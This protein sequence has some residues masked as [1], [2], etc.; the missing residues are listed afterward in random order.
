MYSFGKTFLFL[1][2]TLHEE[3][4]KNIQEIL[5]MCVNENPALR[6][7]D[8]KQVKKQLVNLQTKKDFYRVIKRGCLI[9]LGLSIICGIGIWQYSN[10]QK[11]YA[12]GMAMKQGR[13]EDAMAL[14]IRL[15]PY[16]KGYEA[17]VKQYVEDGKS[18]EEAQKDALQILEAWMRM[19]KAMQDEEIQAYYGFLCLLQDEPSYYRR[20][21]EAFQLSSSSFYQTL[22]SICKM[23]GEDG[24][25]KDDVHTLYETLLQIE[26][27][28]DTLLN[29]QHCIRM[30][31]WLLQIYRYYASSIGDQAYE[32]CITIIE[33]LEYMQYLQEESINIR[34]LYFEIY[35]EK[36]MYAIQNQAYDTMQEAFQQAHNVSQEMRLEEE[37]YLKLFYM[38]VFRIRY[39][40]ISLEKR[41][42]YKA[43]VQSYYENIQQKT[44]QVQQLYED[45]QE[46]GG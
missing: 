24:V 9:L 19:Y 37:Q 32:R 17:V 15:E 1:S 7:N 6:L 2:Q 42:Q 28:M 22:A 43:F 35:Y 3:V 39:E 18:E 46:I 23:L 29:Q 5:N 4:G 44:Q 26:Q 41:K 30:Y 31:E 12:Y 11:E 21:Y 16:Q 38:Y 33:K 14:R 8:F 27:Y 13:Y 20:A 10:Y 36:G 25:Y 45:I 34:I 40:D